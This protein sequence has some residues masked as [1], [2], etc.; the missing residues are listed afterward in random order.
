MTTSSRVKMRANS[1]PQKKVRKNMATPKAQETP[2]ARKRAFE[3]RAGFPFPI[4][5]ATKAD[6]ADKNDMG[7]IERK[8]NSFS[9]MPML[10]DSSS[11]MLLTMAVM[12]RKEMLTKKSCRAIGAPTAAM[13]FTIPF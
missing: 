8:T 4:F 12:M 2:Q 13:L 3:A 11:P 9:A 7:T 5:C 6:R 1:D 10:A